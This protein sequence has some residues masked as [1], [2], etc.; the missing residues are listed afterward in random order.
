MNEVLVC[1]ED[2]S[3]FLEKLDAKASLG[4]TACL[5]LLLLLNQCGRLLLRLRRQRRLRLLKQ[6]C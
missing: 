3:A 2:A 1:A 5:L 6:C 4:F